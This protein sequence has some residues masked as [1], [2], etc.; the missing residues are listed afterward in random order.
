MEVTSMRDRQSGAFPIMFWDE[1]GPDLP[2]GP[3]ATKR[4]RG[5][6]RDWDDYPNYPGNS[7]FLWHPEGKDYFW[8]WEDFLK[9]KTDEEPP[10]F[11]AFLEERRSQ[12]KSRDLTTGLRRGLNAGRRRLLDL[13]ATLAQTPGV[14]RGCRR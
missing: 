9:G 7:R 5:H 1:V 11:G 10:A 3:V 6:V 2:F 4:R 12:A 14:G 8:L 13:P